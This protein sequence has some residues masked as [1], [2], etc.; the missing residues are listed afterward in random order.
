MNLIVIVASVL[1]IITPQV[2]ALESVVA[3]RKPLPRLISD[4][5]SPWLNRTYWICQKTLNVDFALKR[6]EN[7]VLM[8]GTVLDTVEFKA[9]TGD[10]EL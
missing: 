4:V 9:Y 2:V 10:M 8:S 3:A 1:I 7:K 5:P 6:V